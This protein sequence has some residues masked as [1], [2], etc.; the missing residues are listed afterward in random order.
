[1]D[2]CNKKDTMEF[3]V[4]TRIKASAQD[5]YRAWLSSKGHSEMTGGEAVASDQVGEEFS[6]WDGYIEGR[7]I[8]VEPHTRIIQSWRTSEFAEDE[9]DSQIEINL[10][11]QGDETELTLIHTNI[12]EDGTGYKQG[13]EDHYFKPMA[14]YFSK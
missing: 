2:F 10:L 11:E 7:N 9:P 3:K 1:M 5:I 12:P 6:A 8:L 13:W 4:Q 14:A